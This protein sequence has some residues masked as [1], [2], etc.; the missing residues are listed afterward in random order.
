MVTYTFFTV[1][2]G[3]LSI[4]HGEIMFFPLFRLD[5]K[6]ALL[7]HHRAAGGRAQGPATPFS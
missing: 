4:F 2:Y 5:A 6:D 1:K 7:A 3:E